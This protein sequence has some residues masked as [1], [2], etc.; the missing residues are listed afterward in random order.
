LLSLRDAGRVKLRPKRRLARKLGGLLAVE[1]PLRLLH[2]QAVQGAQLLEQRPSQLIV[3]HGDELFTADFPPSQRRV[4]EKGA[5][6][7]ERHWPAAAPAQHAAGPWGGRQGAGAGSA[8]LG[9]LLV[10]QVARP[11]SV[12]GW[13]VGSGLVSFERGAGGTA[14]HARRVT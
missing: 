2:L 3:R 6:Q 14:P 4:V 9:S 7:D 11:P 13:G 12:D 8:T 1:Q 5:N 10:L